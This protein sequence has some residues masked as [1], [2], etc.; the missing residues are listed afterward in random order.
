[1]EPHTS[2]RLQSWR[3]FIDDVRGERGFQCVRQLVALVVA[4]DRLQLGGIGR[5]AAVVDGDINV[6]GE[7][8][9]IAR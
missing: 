3:Q 2:G 7:K 6:L 1:V 5:Q 9:S 4:G 8:R